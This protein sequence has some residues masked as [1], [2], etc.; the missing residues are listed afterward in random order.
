M[1]PNIYVILKSR[2]IHMSGYPSLLVTALVLQVKYPSGIHGV[3][4]DHVL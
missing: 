1:D 2:D 4:Y 3:V